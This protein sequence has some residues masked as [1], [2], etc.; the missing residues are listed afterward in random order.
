MIKN[1]VQVGLGLW[2]RRPKGNPVRWLW[3]ATTSQGVVGAFAQGNGWEAE[4]RCA[5]KMA[6]GKED[7]AAAVWSSTSSNISINFHDSSHLESMGLKNLLVSIP[8]FGN[9]SPL[10]RCVTGWSL[11]WH[12][13][14]SNRTSGDR[15]NRDNRDKRD[16][17]LLWDGIPLN[18]NFNTDKSVG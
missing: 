10:I 3:R 2:Q 9:P 8:A 14:H 7:S 16:L 17:G 18:D 6:H 15:D 4:K 13:F 12:R 1:S 11:W 5:Q